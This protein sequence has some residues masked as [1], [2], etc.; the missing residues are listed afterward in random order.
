MSSPGRLPYVVLL[1]CTTLG[2][3]SSTIIT[4]PINA[5][6]ADLDASAREIVFAVSAFTLAMVLFAP[7]AGWL[8]ERLGARAFLAASLVVM[9]L[10]GIGAAMSPELWVLV[11]MRALQ[12]I[13]CSAVPPAV[14]QTLGAFWSHRRARVMAAW[15][16]AIGVGQA[17]GP[18]LGGLV[19]D[20]AGWRAVFVTHAVLSG[21]LAVLLT[22]FVPAA[23]RGR[24]P[25]H[26]VGMLTLVIGVGGLV[27]GLTWAGQGGAAL[28][29][30]AVSVAGAAA[31]AVHAQV[32]RR[33]PRAL[34]DPRLLVEKRYLRSTASA[35][36]V[37]ACLGVMIVATPLYLGRQF[38]MTPSQ[39]GLVTLALAASMAVSAPLSSRLGDRITPRRVLHVG[40]AGLVVGPVATAVVL[41]APTPSVAV[42]GAVLLLALTGGAI[43]AVQ[44]VS[45][46]G[47]MRSPA[48]AHGT[49]LGIHNMMR[50]AGLAVGYAWVSLSYPTG[51]LALV[52]GGPTL[53]AGS[54]LALVLV[55]PPAAPLPGDDV[56]LA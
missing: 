12:G 1:C 18:P 33:N 55:G 24:P 2:T 50:F 6:A 21:L 31:L 9:A 43:G 16:S 22:L 47:V 32:A 26:V 14:Q 36:T 52:Y 11:L 28:A 37:M 15:A 41:A 49:A 40:L 53:L 46:F 54:T 19:A 20:L 23:R 56:A 38:G 39:I 5:I 45:G 34:V 8:C 10:A 42:G 44:A 17:L 3:L 48:A 29:A 13:A 7:L 35:A 51:Q 25:M 4:S 30:A 27:G